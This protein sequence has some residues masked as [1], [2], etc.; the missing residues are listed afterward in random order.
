[1]RVDDVSL[2]ARG[3]ACTSGAVNPIGTLTATQRFA[4]PL[5]PA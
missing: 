5:R 3:G 2:H 1:M 4:D